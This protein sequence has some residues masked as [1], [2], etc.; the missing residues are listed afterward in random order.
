MS[1]GERP[2]PHA[3]AGRRPARDGSEA[4]EI[5]RVLRRRARHE[6]GARAALAALSM[7]GTPYTWD[8]GA[9]SGPT[10][11]IGRGRHRVGFD[12]SGLT[13]FAH[14][15]AGVSL[16]H[17][18]GSQLHAGRR[19]PYG[20]MR[21]GDLLFFGRDAHHEGIAIGHRLMVHA[22]HPGD[23]VRVASVEGAYRAELLAIV[24]P[25]S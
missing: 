11:G 8:G 3:A 25:S 13:M 7:L 14:A 15:R 22:P 24:R 19:V 6:A 17:F 21:P 2:R 20:R 5:V 9:P 12:C 1:G 4:R 16:D 18:T 23:V 10:R